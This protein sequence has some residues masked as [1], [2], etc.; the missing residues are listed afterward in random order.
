MRRVDDCV[1]FTF[2]LLSRF[3]LLPS[4]LPSFTFNAEIEEAEDEEA[5]KEAEGLVFILIFG[6]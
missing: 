6:L 3:P 2:T 4:F 5:K 1:A